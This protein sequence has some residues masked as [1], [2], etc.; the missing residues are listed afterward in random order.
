MT[1]SCATL[2]STQ[3]QKV[4]FQTG[5]PDVELKVDARTTVKGGETVKLKRGS[6][7]VV[8]VRDS[9]YED[10]DYIVPKKVN[11]VVYG[12]II[13]FPIMLGVGG[14]LASLKQQRQIFAATE[15]TPAMYITEPKEPEAFIGGAML[16]GSWL[17]PSLGAGVD[18][19]SGAVWKFDKT[20]YVKLHRLPELFEPKDAPALRLRSVRTS[21]SE[22]SPVGSYHGR[23]GR[24]TE[25]LNWKRGLYIEGR[26]LTASLETAISDRGLN[27]GGQYNIF[28]RMIDSASAKYV[29]DIEVMRLQYDVF[30]EA[31]S[32]NR[33]YC[34]LDV[35]WRVLDA[36]TEDL[37]Y[38][39]TTTA[40]GQA[41]TS[42]GSQPMHNAMRHAMY[43]LVE[44]EKFRKFFEP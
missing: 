22:G 42:G 5:D 19:L 43:K 26:E 39:N 25:M 17:P 23:M 37:L 21:F 1:T 40:T 31:I 44:D 14:Y 9:A 2:L 20:I 38:T 30:V 10:V 13:T 8:Q 4:I 24:P 28:G 35:R 16:F 36:Q 6:V 3:H 33:T 18:I 11:P 7:Y 34:E 29:L 15:F 32:E 12:N 27:V 41:R